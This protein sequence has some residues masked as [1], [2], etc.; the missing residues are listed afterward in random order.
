M[1]RDVF[2]IQAKL[3]ARGIIVEDSIIRFVKE[4][5]ITHV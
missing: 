4:G 1:E 3:T 5:F 2:I